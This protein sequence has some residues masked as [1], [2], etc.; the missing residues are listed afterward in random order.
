MKFTIPRKD[1]LAAIAAV[2]PAAAGSLPILNQI[3]IVAHE[4]SVTLTAT[5]LD[6]YIRVN[7]DADVSGE[8][9][10]TCRATLLADIIKAADAADVVLSTKGRNLK[11]E[12][13]AAKHEVTT[14][15]PE[16]FPPFP[17]VS[18]KGQKT[19]PVQDFALEDA[20]FRTMLTE[21]VFACSDDETRLVLNGCL[22]QLESG[23]LTVAGCNGFQLALSTCD[24][25][26]RENQTMIIPAAT[27][28][29]LLR[30][31][32]GD[33]EKP[34]RLTVT[35][36]VNL[37]QFS[38]GEITIVSKLIEGQY[39]DWRK[40]LPAENLTACL[41]RTELLRSIGRIALV[42]DQ[43]RLTFSTRSLAITSEGK[44]GAEYLGEA[45]DSLLTP[46]NHAA[47][48]LFS[49]RYLL[50]ILTAVPDQDLEVHLNPGGRTLFKTTGRGWRAI[51]SPVP[52]AKDAAKAPAS[53]PN[54]QSGAGVP[55]AIP[56]GSDPAHGQTEVRPA[57]AA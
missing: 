50:D 2:K 10:V 33:P 34:H 37:A 31:L 4:K 42:A 22:V 41:P 9:K 52:P 44:R 12:C 47:E 28:R 30:L 26:A 18:T 43:V 19:P 45:S 3:L 21:T 20:V 40:I 54:P 15:D 27:V 55:P 48:A 56:S 8:G 5:N 57:K 39:P 1:L 7:T 53:K 16:E 6:L 23:R 49:T 29:E 38:F 25:P 24:T 11:I 14:L 46:A 51:L 35:A 17:R 36:G 13:G 32:G